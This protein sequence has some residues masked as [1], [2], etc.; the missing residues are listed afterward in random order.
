M[1]DQ[2]PNI[3][4]FLRIGEAARYL[5]VSMD[6]LRNWDRCGKLKPARNPANR[7]RLYSPEQLSAFLSRLG[8]PDANVVSTHD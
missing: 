3:G 4:A 6:T 8:S 1:P 7:Y 5:G 2:P